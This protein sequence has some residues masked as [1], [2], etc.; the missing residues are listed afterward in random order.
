ME[1]PIGIGIFDD[2]KGSPEFV[3]IKEELSSEIKRFSDAAGIE[4]K[5]LPTTGEQIGNVA[6]AVSSDLAATQRR[7]WQLQIS[8]FQAAGYSVEESARTVD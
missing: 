4:I 5:I 6:F 1:K 2:T 8:L 3:R 7:L